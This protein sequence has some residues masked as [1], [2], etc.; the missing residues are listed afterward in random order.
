LDGALILASSINLGLLTE[1]HRLKSVLLG[2][3]P[4][5]S[6]SNVAN[7]YGLAGAARA[8]AVCAAARGGRCAVARGESR[9]GEFAAGHGGISADFA[10]GRRAARPCG[11]VSRAAA[12]L[13][14]DRARKGIGGGKEFNRTERAREVIGSS[15]VKTPEEAGLYVMPEGMTHKAG[16]LLRSFSEASQKLL[17]NL[18]TCLRVVLKLF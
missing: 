13:D 7:D 6:L 9:S 2:R 4:C 10:G 11:A 8:R 5:R 3:R 15:G 14:A 12:H 16:E 18:E 17:R 1:P